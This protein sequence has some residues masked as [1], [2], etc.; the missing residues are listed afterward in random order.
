MQRLQ[1]LAR[2]L[3]PAK[4]WP[5]YLMLTEVLSPPVLGILTTYDFEPPL[6]AVSGAAW[7]MIC[8]QVT[9]ML[10]QS[11]IW[12]GYITLAPETTICHLFSF[13][14]YFSSN[15][16]AAIIP[17]VSQHQVD[18]KL[19]NGS[20]TFPTIHWYLVLLSTRIDSSKNPLNDFWL[21][22]PHFFDLNKLGSSVTEC[23]IF[24]KG[25][26]SLSL[27][28]DEDKKYR[29]YIAIFQKFVIPSW[30]FLGMMLYSSPVAIQA[31]LVDG[32]SRYQRVKRR[33]QG[34]NTH[35]V[36][37]TH[38]FHFGLT[39]S[40]T[41]RIISTCC[42]YSLLNS[43]CTSRSKLKTVDMHKIIKI[44]LSLLHLIFKKNSWKERVTEKKVNL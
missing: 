27:D 10:F 39:Q 21:Y 18:I 31:D 8:F 12:L 35:S 37:D 9:M 28:N 3:I 19:F 41:V 43:L 2:F 14:G 5:S 32:I 17:E 13:S 24:R 26:F 40:Y 22:L 1:L 16:G 33:P 6:R 42:V 29:G 23:A 11:I 34:F 20:S 30:L 25:S 38:I 4:S 15:N 7:L 36:S 44:T